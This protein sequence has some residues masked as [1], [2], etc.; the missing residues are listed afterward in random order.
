MGIDYRAAMEPEDFLGTALIVH[1]V[2]HYTKENF[3]T[4]VYK[5]G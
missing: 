4:N 2:I 1:S 5:Q 3:F